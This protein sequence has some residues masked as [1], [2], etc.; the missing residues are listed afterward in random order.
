MFEGCRDDQGFDFSLHDLSLAY[1]SNVWFCFPV[2]PEISENNPPLSDRCLKPRGKTAPSVCQYL[3]DKA[4]LR[5]ISQLRVEIYVRYSL[6]VTAESTGTTAL[7]VAFE[8]LGL[9][10]VRF[11][12]QTNANVEGAENNGAKGVWRGL[13]NV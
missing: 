6:Y 3:N 2:F 12:L 8:T 10:P 9:E 5:S 7:T 13:E 11:P 1:L 4:W